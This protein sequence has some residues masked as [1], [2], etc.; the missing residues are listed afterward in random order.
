MYEEQALARSLDDISAARRSI[1]VQVLA[2][3]KGNKSPLNQWLM[4]HETTLA[5]I[6]GQLSPSPRA[7][8]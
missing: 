1:A 3:A 6:T 5:R 7:A 8:T 4:A 2:D